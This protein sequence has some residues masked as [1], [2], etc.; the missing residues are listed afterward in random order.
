MGRRDKQVL[1]RNQTWRKGRMMEFQIMNAETYAW[2]SDVEGIEN[3][4][5]QLEATNFKEK[6]RVVTDTTVPGKAK[7]IY[8]EIKT[9]DELKELYKTFDSNLI[10]NFDEKYPLIV[11][12]DGYIEQN[13]NENRQTESVRKVQWALRLLRQGYNYKGYDSYDKAKRLLHILNGKEKL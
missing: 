2:F 13:N 10:L 5:A 4:L 1:F 9:L 3:I 8:I 6:I 11:I 12:Y 7:D